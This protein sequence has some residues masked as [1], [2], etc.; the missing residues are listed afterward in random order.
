LLGGGV[1]LAFCQAF[2]GTR[3]Y[4]P[5]KMTE[6]HKIAVAIGYDAACELADN[7]GG[8][9]FEVPKGQAATAMQIRQ[10]I[11][12]SGASANSLAKLFPYT[13]RHIKRMRAD[14][15]ARKTD[16]NQDDLFSE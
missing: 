1:T 7:L 2:G 16:P 8:E 12:T 14:M 10:A 13:L 5:A 11:R 4:I 9:A 6:D 3:L 15:K